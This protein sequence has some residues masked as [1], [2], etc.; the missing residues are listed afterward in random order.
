[1]S[2]RYRQDHGAEQAQEPLVWER[3]IWRQGDGRYVF[4][5]AEGGLHATLRSPHGSC[6]TLPVIAW[7]GLMD[8]LAGARKTRARGERGFPVR[9]GVRWYAGEAGELA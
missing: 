4:E 2:E 8:A 3:V 5:V 9:S 6:L 1:M 7:E